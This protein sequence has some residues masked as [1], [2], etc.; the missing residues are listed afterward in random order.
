MYRKILVPLDGSDF[1]EHALPLAFALAERTAGEV[2]LVTSVPTLPPVVPAQE[3]EGPVRG[4][5]EEERVRGTEYLEKVRSRLEK[6][7]GPAVH[8]RVLAGEPA[9]TLDER[10]RRTGVDLTVM[11]THGRGPFERMWLGSVADGLIR[12]APCP[13]LLWRPDEG[14]EDGAADLEVRPRF[15]RILVPLDGSDASESMM[16]KAIAMARLFEARLSLVS[17]VPEP[18]PLGSTYIPHAAHENLEHEEAKTEA[19]AYLEE[20]ADAAR[21]E[22]IETDVEVVGEDDAGSGILGYREEIE[23]DLVAMSTRGRGG[24][25]RL[26]LGSVADKVIRG[27]RVPVFVHRQPEKAGTPAADTV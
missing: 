8:T 17:V 13:I 1:A 3:S 20:V 21:S 22:G 4:W 19:R 15:R 5:F 11:T 10:I 25:A 14:V 27:A 2:H 9:Q 7:G 12:R 16:P 18:F 24:V 23:A 26:V 6:S